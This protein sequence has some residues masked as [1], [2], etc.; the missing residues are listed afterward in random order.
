MSYIFIIICWNV[1]SVLTYKNFNLIYNELGYAE[2][3]MLH[4]KYDT[5]T[6]STYYCMVLLDRYFVC[7]MWL[8]L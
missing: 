8:L 3:Y 1:K 5:L 7:T 2:A 6:A 4:I